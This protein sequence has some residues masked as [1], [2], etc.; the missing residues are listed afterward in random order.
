[1]DFI[2]TDVIPSVHPSPSGAFVSNR[3]EMLCIQP[4]THWPF[5][6]TRFTSPSVSDP[7]FLLA[8]RDTV[9]PC[10]LWLLQGSNQLMSVYFQYVSVKTSFETICFYLSLVYSLDK[11]IFRWKSFWF[12]P[13]KSLEPTVLL[14]TVYSISTD[15]R[16]MK[17]P[18]SC[19]VLGAFSVG[20]Q[21]HVRKGCYNNFAPTVYCW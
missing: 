1:M 16:S 15:S 17:P 8:G 4:S 3:S 20:T 19:F 18:S 14:G 7:Y 9:R 5:V 6:G 21:Q 10:F 12:E 13:W 11:D 2:V